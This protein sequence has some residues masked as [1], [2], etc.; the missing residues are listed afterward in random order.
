MFQIC[1]ETQVDDLFFH[2]NPLTSFIDYGLI[3]H[4]IKRFSSDSLK[5]GMQSYCSDMQTFF[6]ETTIKELINLLPGQQEAPKKFSILKAKIGEN[7]ST[8]TL[9]RIN[10]LRKRFYAEVKLSEVVFCLI[11]LE[12]SDS[13]IVSWLVPSMLVPVLIKSAREIKESFFDIENINSLSV[14]SQYLYSKK[15]T[16]FGA[17]LK[18]QYQQFQGS[19]PPVE[20]IPSPTKKIFQLAMIQGE[21]MQQGFI[22]DRF[23]RMTISG[24]VDDILHAKFPVELEHIFRKTL[25]GEEIVLIEGAPGSGKSTLTVHICQRWGKGE[26][27]QQFSV[28]ILVQL[29]D[30]AVQRAQTIADLLPVENVIVAQELAT[31]VIATNGRGVLWVFDG[32]DELPTHL[33]QDSIFHKLVRPNQTFRY[34]PLEPGKRRLLHECSVIITSRPISSGDLHPVVSSRIEVLGFASEEQRQYFTECL[35]GD[36]KALEALLGKTLENPVAQSI[37]YL[38]LNAAF[39]VHS[40]KCKGQLL[41]NTV[42]EVYSTVILSC[43]Q[44]HFERESRGH[45]LPLSIETLHDLSGSEAVREPFQSLC[46]LAYHGVMK[47]KMTFSSSDLP[48]GSNTLSLLQAI[49][50]FLQNGKSVFYN[51]LHLSIQEVLSAYYIAAC[52]SDS[53]QVSQFQQLFTQPRFTAVFQ[54][55]TSITKLNNPGMRQVIASIIESKSYPLLVS[56]LRCLYEAQDPSLCL[57]VAERLDYELYLSNTPLSSLDY[58]SISFFATSVTGK[59]ICVHLYRCYIDELGVKFFTK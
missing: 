7:A 8:C 51:F 19:P 54:F 18:H 10:T 40:F 11:A 29:R 25:D 9:E 57:Y 56:L 12:D 41:V 26:L 58:L 50:S 28:V 45:E 6:K 35:K 44:R 27:F 32:W 55:Y 17:I 3:E 23:V 21:E 20:W 43:I 34:M 33:Q 15:L 48:Q 4:F 31:E 14:S 13:F 39:V 38:P 46:E 37:C 16:S 53:E 42:Y 49:E 1:V 30:P 47:N 59:E 22:E 2:L 24:R 52:S 36:T 5:R